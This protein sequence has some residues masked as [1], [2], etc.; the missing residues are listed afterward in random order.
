MIHK[1]GDFETGSFQTVVKRQDY[2]SRWPNIQTKVNE[3]NNLFPAEYTGDGYAA[4]IKNTWLTYNPYKDVDIKSQVSIPFKYN[5]CE[6]ITISYSRFG[7][8]IINEYS[9]S[10][11]I[12][13]SNFCSNSVYGLREDVITITGCSV[14]PSFIYKD[15]GRIKSTVVKSWDNGTFILKVTHN[16]PMDIDIKCSGKATGRLTN[17]PSKANIIAPSKPPVYY[18][19]RQ[20]EAENFDFRNITSV[21]QTDLL[22]YTAMGYLNFGSNTSARIM[23]TVNVPENGVYVLKTRYRS[24]SVDVKTIDLY[25]DNK[26]VTTPVFLKTVNDTKV[27]EHAQYECVFK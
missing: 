5:T 3:F 20:Y 24:P 8:G 7:N 9:D 18:G 4:R 1:A 17:F 23:D 12:Y 13:L 22:N 14:E 11:H 26:K 2:S 6:N 19:P 16:G 25:I 15:R 21:S 27:L 10:L